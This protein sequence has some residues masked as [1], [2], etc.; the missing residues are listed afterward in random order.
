[1]EKQNKNNTKNLKK[2]TLF[3]SGISTEIG[4]TV[5]AAIL[6]ESLQADYWKPIQSG[7]LHHTD[8]MKVQA[9][10]SNSKTQFH[11]ESYRLKTPASPHHSANIDGI[12]IKLPHFQLPN[13][14]NHLIIEGAGGL[15]VPL[16]KQHLLI[17]LMET[18]QVPVVL[19]SQNYLGSI[20]HTLLSTEAL[21]K[22]NIPIAG[23]IFNGKPTPSTQD[24]II[25]YSG[26][27]IL[28]HILPEK[29]ITPKIV[30]HYANQFQRNLVDVLAIDK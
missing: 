11:K 14:N 28:G 5:A 9:L 8:T 13:T 16:N 4:K 25:H 17:D 20:N 3:V 24:I 12:K 26:C 19:V 29:E 6:V 21:Q 15:M 1:M 22:R 18:L 10:I 23:I 7:D 27:K 2:Q 30:S